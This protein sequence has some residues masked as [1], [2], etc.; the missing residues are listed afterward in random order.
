VISQLTR[1]DLVGRALTAFATVPLLGEMQDAHELP[2]YVDL[3]AEAT[4]WGYVCFA[5]D[6]EVEVFIAG[7]NTTWPAA[8]VCEV[9]VPPGRVWA[10]HAQNPPHRPHDSVR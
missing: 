4:L 9:S 7:R 1:R 8:Q 3:P 10:S 6:R 5:G 2:Y